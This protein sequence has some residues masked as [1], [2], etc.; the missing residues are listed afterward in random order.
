WQ[1]QWSQQPFVSKMYAGTAEFQEFT[2]WEEINQFT[3]NHIKAHPEPIPIPQS[4]QEYNIY[5]LGET[6]WVFFNKV[7]EQGLVRES[8]FMVKEEGKWKIARMQTIF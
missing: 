2:T 6:A 5:L 1:R 8:R 3:L 4:D 7:G